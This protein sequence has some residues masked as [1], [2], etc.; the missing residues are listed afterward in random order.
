MKDGSGL[1][2]FFSLLIK[3]VG[4]WKYIIY[5]SGYIRGWPYNAE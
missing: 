1:P 3:C 2:V 4:S 5:F